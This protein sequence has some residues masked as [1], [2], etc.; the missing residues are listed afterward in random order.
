LTGALPALVLV[1]AGPATTLA[2]L[3]QQAAAPL[4]AALGVELLEPLQ[5]PSPDPALEALATATGVLAPLPIDPGLPLEEGRHWAAALGAWRQPAL[6][7][8][9]ADQV[10]S[11]LPAALHALMVVWQVP[12]LG[13]VQ[14]GGRWDPQ[15]RR[16]DG[17]PWLGRLAT[18]GTGDLAEAGPAAS[19]PEEQ[20]LELRQS[21]AARWAGLRSSLEEAPLA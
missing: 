15:A 7:L 16:R 5:A 17:L 8:V 10:E 18:D 9:A 14:W 2:A 13:L 11:G 4:A 20:A 19:T 6:L 21:V 1:A 3:Q 12:T